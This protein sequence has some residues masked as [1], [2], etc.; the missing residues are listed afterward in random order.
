M[1]LFEFIRVEGAWGEQTIKVWEFL[2]LF[3]LSRNS[4]AEC[5]G[6]TSYN[7]AILMYWKQYLIFESNI[8]A[9]SVKTEKNLEKLRPAKPTA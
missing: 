4:T 7:D 8:L 3:H 9:F 5:N 2:T 6:T 1:C